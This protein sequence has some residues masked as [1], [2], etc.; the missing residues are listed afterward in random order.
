MNS[1][2]LNLC[3]AL[4]L[5]GNLLKIL[6]PKSKPQSSDFSAISTLKQLNLNLIKKN[7]SLGIEAEKQYLL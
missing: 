4:E 2:L 1:L 6:V 3:C 5:S 7:K